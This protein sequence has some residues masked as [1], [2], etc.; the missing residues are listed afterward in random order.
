M[1]RESIADLAADPANNILIF[2]AQTADSNPLN[3]SYDPSTGLF[4]GGDPQHRDQ[5]DL[6]R[7]GRIGALA[8]GRAAIFN[9]LSDTIPATAL[10]ASGLPAQGG[11]RITHVYRA[12]ATNLILT[13]AHDSGT[14]L[15]VPLQAANGAGFTV[16]DGGS[17]ASPGAIINA[18]AAARIDATHLSVTLAAPMTNPSADILLFYPY[19]SKQIGRGDAV[20][21]NAAL[22]APPANWNIAGDL[23]SAWSINLPLQAT[24]YPIILSD[25]PIGFAAAIRC[26]GDARRYRQVAAG[27]RRARR[28]RRRAGELARTLSGAGR[29]DRRQ[30]VHQGRRANRGA[31]RVP[32]QSLAS[33]RRT[34]CGAA[35]HH[36][37]RQPA[38]STLRRPG[39]EFPAYFGALTWTIF[40]AASRLL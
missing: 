25:Q 11:P 18:I 21:D 7:Y 38:L 5:P 16:M 36:D 24:C 20:T 26:R 14:D 29:P 23:G 28:A 37:H 13:I 19:G 27:L 2:A 10:P 9:G 40:R 3:A 22:L 6:L 15:I 32:F 1:V 12:S 30:A 31:Q 35:R 17:I 4:S 34:R 33:F 8:A 39:G